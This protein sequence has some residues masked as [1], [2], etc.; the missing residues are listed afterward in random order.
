MDGCCLITAEKKKKES[1]KWQGD[2]MVTNYLHIK[3]AV[4]GTFEVQ[5]SNGLFRRAMTQSSR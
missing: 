5:T 1:G 3:G 2:R 4:R